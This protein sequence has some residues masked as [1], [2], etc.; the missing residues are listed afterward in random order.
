M[1]EQTTHQI[2]TQNNEVGNI[3]FSGKENNGGF[4]PMTHDETKKQERSRRTEKI[5]GAIG[6]GLMSLSNLFFTTKGAP[7]WIGAEDK[8]GKSKKNNIFLTSAINEHHQKED[9][10]YE[11]KYSRWEKE[12]ERIRKE[13]EKFE[14]RKLKE[15][16]ANKRVFL[17][18][19]FGFLE[20]NWTDEDF[21]NRLYEYLED[22]NQDPN[23]TRIM[24]EV[25]FRYEPIW[26]WMGSNWSY[27]VGHDKKIDLFKGKS[28][29]Y[30]K[31]DIIETL[32]GDDAWT[33]EENRNNLMRLFSEFEQNWIKIK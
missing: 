7:S 26:E 2:P 10:E 24:N 32:F 30:L 15:E 33:T 22:A 21:I 29:T 28:G 9:A 18:D 23:L 3:D 6:D 17:R 31:R 14:L 5:I 4:K 11:K 20:R 13:R 19:Q 16:E 1:D 27:E 25:Q 12:Q 8:S